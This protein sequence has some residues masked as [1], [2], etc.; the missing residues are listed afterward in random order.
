MNRK[1]PMQ[2]QTE[3]GEIKTFSRKDFIKTL[4]YS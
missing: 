1:K 4:K 3:E 2:P